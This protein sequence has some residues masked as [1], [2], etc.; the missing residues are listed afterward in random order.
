MPSNLFDAIDL[1]AN[2]P[3]FRD[4]GV[5][6]E[7]VSR[8]LEAG[9][10]PHHV[11][12][13]LQIA[14]ADLVAALASEP[15]GPANPLGL[16][17]VQ[18]PPPRPKLKAAL[19]AL[20]PLF[21][22]APPA[23]VLALAAGLFQLFDFWHESHESAQQAEDQG[24][25]RVSAYWHAIA[26]RREPDPANTRYWIRRVGPHPVYSRVGDDIRQHQHHLGNIATSLLDPQGHLNPIA[27][28]DLCTRARAGS[29]HE[30][31]ARLVQRLELT[32]LLEASLNPLR[33]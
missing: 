26:H 30:R 14:A 28:L 27:L 1:A 10:S 16:A 32:R 15:L 23:S 4:N 13:R 9:D 20:R 17:L 11:C 6:L 21:P 31:C 12:Q 7:D 3:A 33:T 29:E 22:G 18:A 24:E 25:S 8:A 19:G 2:P 5:L